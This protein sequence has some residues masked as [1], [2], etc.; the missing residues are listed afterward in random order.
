MDWLDEYVNDIV[1]SEKKDNTFG[2]VY[3]N[4]KEA[5]DYFNELIKLFLKEKWQPENTV[6]VNR[7][8]FSNAYMRESG[9]V[10]INVGLIA[11]ASNEAEL[12]STLG[13]EIGHYQKQHSCKNF[14]KYKETIGKKDDAISFYGSGLLRNSKKAIKEYYAYS[15]ENES[16][17]DAI[18]LDLLAASKF[19]VDRNAYHFRKSL[20]TV[21]K[22]E[23]RKDYVPHEYLQTHP[24]TTERINIAEKFAKKTDTTGRR[25][26]LLDQNRF[27]QLRKQA[28]DECLFLAFREMEF[29][30]AIE[31]CYR[32]LMF[33]PNDEFYL[34]FLNESL[35]RYLY[36][37]PE[38]AT[39]CFITDKYKLNQ[40]YIPKSDLPKVCLSDLAKDKKVP[41]YYKTINYNYQFI[42]FKNDKEDISALPVNVLTSNDTIEF[43]TYK[44][45]LDYF[46]GRQEKLNQESV[47][48][49][50]KMKGNATASSFNSV[51]PDIKVYNDFLAAYP[52]DT[53]EVYTIIPLSINYDDNTVS[54]WGIN[55]NSNTNKSTFYTDVLK[56]L[57]KEIQAPYKLIDYSQFSPED[58]VLLYD[59]LSG[60]RQFG[61]SYT[62][63]ETFYK[64][65]RNSTFNYD[66]FKSSPYC[67]STICPELVPFFKSHGLNKVIFLK[68]DVSE[69]TDNSGISVGHGFVPVGAMSGSKKIL[70]FSG[71]YFDVD[72]NIFTH[73]FYWKKGGKA[74]DLVNSTAHEIYVFG[75]QMKRDIEMNRTS[76]E[77]K[78]Q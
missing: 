41:E 44:E 10:Y 33:D 75:K 71:Y 34:F 25:D 23:L 56:S 74:T 24:P 54:I 39:A 29:H 17:A 40:K 47:S 2:S 21:K 42:L 53:S 30:D 37:Y 66:V 20:E 8:P 4:W 11:N 43:I 49:I 16:E 65:N 31:L 64:T 18:S 32:Q 19:K 60:L 77:I 70:T 73:K 12:A 67:V 46:I 52:K 78:A 27:R 1:L 50:K 7:D 36:M 38:K 15:R 6:V 76:T 45:A 61:L 51:Y 55:N 69:Y 68:L 3:K 14:L 63:V 26:F 57:E 35:R 13:H 72:K 28:I 62:D 22:F 58:R 5:D 9:K 59:Q 48:F